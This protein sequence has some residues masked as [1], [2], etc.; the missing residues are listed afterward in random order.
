LDQHTQLKVAEEE[1]MA[2]HL[3]QRVMDNQVVLVAVLQEGALHIR[4]ALLVGHLAGQQIQIHHLL[5]LEMM[6]V[7]ILVG[8]LLLMALLVVA[9][10][11]VLEQV[12]H[13]QQVVATGVLVYK[14]HQHLEIHYQR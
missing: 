10:Q 11:E 8:L 6:V 2:A 12:E 5:D 7:V 14:F 9:E 13:C 4:V 3:N 1:V